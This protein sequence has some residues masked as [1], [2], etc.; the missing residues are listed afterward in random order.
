LYAT[1]VGQ[2]PASSHACS[3]RVRRPLTGGRVGGA[4]PGVDREL[5][6]RRSRI[7]RPP[8]P[9][10]GSARTD[11]T[12]RP[13]WREVG[14]SGKMQ[15]RGAAGGSRRPAT[16]PHRR[17]D[18]GYHLAGPASRPAPKQV[19]RVNGIP[20]VPGSSQAGCF[21]SGTT[22]RGTWSARA[23]PIGER[24]RTAQGTLAPLDHRVGRHTQ[25]L[26]VLFA[27]RRLGRSRSGCASR[28]H[29]RWDASPPAVCGPPLITCVQL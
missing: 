26:P 7:G 6:R 25:L 24:V 5:Q 3:T 2:L 14:S 4:A 16:P 17:R 18:R 21:I 22:A 12:P 23:F 28:A 13:P 29:A 10:R 9:P 8:A 27:P 19:Q 11:P 20:I 1:Q 15:D